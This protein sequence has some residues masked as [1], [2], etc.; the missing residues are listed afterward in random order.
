MPQSARFD[1]RRQPLYNT[2]LYG[3]EGKRL[4]ANALVVGHDVKA[5]PRLDQLAQNA[6]GPGQKQ[7]C[8]ALHQSG[9]RLETEVSRFEQQVGKRVVI[10]C[11]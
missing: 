5:E 9:G 10:E 4:A 7:G 1:S 3:F 2:F 8:Y 11:L 6:R